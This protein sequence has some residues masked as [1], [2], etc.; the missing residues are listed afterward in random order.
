MKLFCYL[1][2]SHLNPRPVLLHE[3]DNLD[4]LKSRA[5]RYANTNPSFRSDW[6]LNGHQDCQELKIEFDYRLVIQA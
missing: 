5:V 4:E 1:K 2:N 6:E 3:S